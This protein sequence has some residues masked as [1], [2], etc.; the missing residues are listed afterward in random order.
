MKIVVFGDSVAKGII[1]QEGKIQT[2]PENAVRRISEHYN[3]EIDNVSQ[4][5]QTLKRL[6]GKGIVDRYVESCAGETDKYAVI[7][8]GGNDSDYPW[9]EVA[10]DPQGHHPAKTPVAEF[11]ALYE[12]MIVKLQTNGFKVAVSTIFPID[13]HRFF[14]NVISKLAD[15]K[16]VLTFLKGDIDIIARHQDVFSV[17]CRYLAEEHGC[18][19]IDI[20]GR[21]QKEPE[22]EKY[23][24]PDGIHPTEDGYRFLAEVAMGEIEQSPVLSTWMAD[25]CLNV[26]GTHEETPIPS[27]TEKTPMA[28]AQKTQRS[29]S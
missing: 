9:A 10:K 11:A 3:L 2:I 14:D 17:I 15:P 26:A 29:L 12:E 1:F 6:L 18:P 27:E 19:V 28:G 21:I 7:A 5:G 20:R 25:A 13:S 23:F 22:Y 4:Y 24:C 16:A 8:I